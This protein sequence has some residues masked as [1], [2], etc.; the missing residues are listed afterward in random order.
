[1]ISWRSRLEQ[2]TESKS[3]GAA[4]R[5]MA[6]LLKVDEEVR[7]ARASAADLAFVRAGETAIDLVAAACE[8]YADR[9]CLAMRPGLG[10][11]PAILTYDALWRRVVALASAW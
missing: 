1:M 10:G 7:R 8:R 9:P 3:I 6:D 4:V 2:M 11:E 5:R